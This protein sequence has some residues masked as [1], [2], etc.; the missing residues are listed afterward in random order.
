MA[1]PIAINE[2]ERLRVIAELDILQRGNDSQLDALVHTAALITGR[3]IA[4]ISIVEGRRQRF[5]ANVGLENTQQ[6]R[7]EV[8]FCA[9][10]IFSEQP[11]DVADALE[12]HRFEGNELVLGEPGIRAYTGVPLVLGNGVAVGTLCVIDRKPGQLSSAQLD[13]LKLLAQAATHRIETADSALS[14]EHEPQVDSVNQRRLLRAVDGTR[15]GTWEWDVDAEQMR[16][17]GHWEAMLGLPRQGQIYVH[18]W[19]D[20]HH[21][22][23]LGAT[24][25]LLSKVSRGECAEYER[26]ARMRRRD[27]SWLWV[28]DRAHVSEWHDDGRPKVLT[29]VRIDM[30]G[31]MRQE[32]RATDSERR[33]NRVGDIASIGCWELE[34]GNG[35]LHWSDE[36]FRIHGLEVGVLPS[37]ETA[38]SFYPGPARKTLEDAIER[39]RDQGEPYDL[40]LPFVRASGESAWIR[41]IGQR[42]PSPIGGQRLVGI[43]Q[44]ITESHRLHARIDE[45]QARMR[46]TLAALDDAVITTD[47]RGLVISLNPVAERMTG[48]TTENARGVPA[49]SVFRIFSGDNREPA[50]NPVALCLNSGKA[51]HAQSN[52]VLLARSGAS[53]GI[54]ETTTPIFD[55]ERLIRGTVIVFRDVTEQRELARVVDH[56]AAHDELTGLRNRREFEQ[57]LNQI[58]PLARDDRASHGLLY[59][60]LD[61]FKIINDS[62]GHK[63]GDRLIK[64]V[65]RMLKACLD[66]GDFIAR[67]GGDEFAVI[68]EQCSSSRLMEVGSEMVAQLRK[69][70]FVEEGQRLRVGASIGAV[71]IDLAWESGEQ[72]LQAADAACYSAKEAGRGRVHLWEQEDAALQARRAD[73][74]W[75][76]RL[77]QAMEYDHFELW[78]QRIDALS[79]DGSEGAY[80]EVLIRLREP[81]GRIVSPA[82]FMGAAE[83][84]HLATRIDQQV[85]YR[86]VGWLAAHSEDWDVATLAVNLSG[87]SVSDPTF[88]VFALSLFESL[89]ESVCKRLCLEITETVAVSNLDAVADFVRV[90]RAMGVRV[91]LDDFGAGA[92]TFGY[93]KAIPVDI[94]KIDGQFVRDLLDDPLDAATVRCFADVAKVIGVKTVAE[95]VE[96]ETIA[97]ALREIGIDYIQ[98]FLRHKPQPLEIALQGPMEARSLFGQVGR[99]QG[100]AG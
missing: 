73:I 91:A 59:I 79:T 83:R 68:L 35:D 82:L 90:V 2:T 71:M 17:N 31:A 78:A 44:D 49:A 18:S 64:Q 37:V 87:N 45:D 5:I 8:A 13:T 28:L 54:Q 16:V 21:P 76:T 98:G 41:A 81:D 11:L 84:F 53:Y 40:E 22:E 63:A 4:L 30:A 65:A 52:T 66:S 15:T 1:P 25:D 89:D 42:E 36:V 14:L 50:T 75:A 57:R 12:D 61:E 100:A 72:V 95:C 97:D 38:L 58:V 51:V 46:A 92:A 56:T 27:G 48:W 47:A 85:L 74:R 77:E 23:E 29:G 34:L 70:R 39:C 7:R 32:A 96:T 20:L 67:T 55:R 33:L 88:R 62:C 93:L 69:F 6:T 80:A 19:L 24:A 9:H 94:I 10:A 86:T 60:D 43:F 99:D 26:L 3:P